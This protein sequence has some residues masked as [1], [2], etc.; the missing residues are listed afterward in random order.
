M[1]PIL[2]T[3]IATICAMLPLIFGHSETGSIVSQSL[4]IV[5]IGGLAVAT[6]LTLIVVPVIYELLYFRKSAKQR[7]AQ[8][9]AAQLS[10]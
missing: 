3:A 8:A 2:M 6:V 10:A 1:R 4:A 9:N 7:K 5:V